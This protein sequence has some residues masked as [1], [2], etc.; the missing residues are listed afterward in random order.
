MSSE[1]QIVQ[2]PALALNA[3][4][5][6]P[7]APPASAPPAARRAV[8]PQSASSEQ[9]TAEQQNTPPL[10]FQLQIDPETQRVIIEAREPVTGFVVFQSPPKTAFSSAG[11]ATPS[12]A[13][14]KSIDRAI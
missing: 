6:A 10:G 13:R 9:G 14:G 8:V 5:T 12:N 3:R 11:D 4:V 7:T 2:P 1:T